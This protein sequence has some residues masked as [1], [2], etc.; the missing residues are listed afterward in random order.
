MTGGQYKDE[1]IVTAVG[2][3]GDN[4]GVAVTTG[5][6]LP[7]DIV[8]GLLPT[9]SHSTI[10]ESFSLTVCRGTVNTVWAASEKWAT[11]CAMCQLHAIISQEC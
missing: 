6:S 7:L 2:A 1:A 4:K 10:D 8:T 5:M 3:S 11:R 9:F